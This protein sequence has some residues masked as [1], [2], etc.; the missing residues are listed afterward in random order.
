MDPVHRPLLAVAGDLLEDVVVWGVG[1][2]ERGT[3]NP[4]RVFRSQGGSAA[5]VAVR[6]AGMD[7]VRVRFL[8]RVGDDAIG[9]ALEAE[10]QGRGIE[11]VLQRGGTTGT[12]IVLV[13]AVGERTMIPDRAASAEIERFPSEALDG[14][15]W[16]HLPLY[17]FQTPIAREA[18]LALASEA[19][20]RGVTVSIDLSSVSLLRDLGDELDGLV[21]AIRPEVV[22]ANAEEAAVVDARAWVQDLGCELVAKNGAGPVLIVSRSGEQ[23]FPV[24]RVEAVSD[25]TGAGDSFAAGY[26]AASLRGEPVEAAVAAGCAAA[27]EVLAAPGSRRA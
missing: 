1:A 4:G 12:V 6:A 25:T 3:D 24:P 10:L 20:D 26:L 2:L 13:D 15:A 9:G 17:G 23:S 16:L 14:V 27:A 22:F 21:A 7:G 11:T 18:L 5:N 8:G 19:R